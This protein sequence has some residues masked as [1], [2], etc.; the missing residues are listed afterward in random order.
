MSDNKKFIIYSYQALEFDKYY[1]SPTW[2]VMFSIIFVLLL[3]YAIIQRSPITFVVFVL[4]FIVTLLISSKDPKEILVEI[5]KI[6]INLDKKTTFRYQDIDSFGIFIRDDVRFISIYLT[7]GMMRYARI[8]LG[9][10]NPE[11]IADI[12]EQYIPREDGKERF[13]DTIDHI[14]KI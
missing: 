8:P 14:L 12:L 11:D 5:T 1:K 10:E 13:M 7:E 3:I 2:Y 4:L 6:G 9:E